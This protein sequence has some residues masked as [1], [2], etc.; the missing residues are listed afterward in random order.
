MGN[1]SEKSQG[2]DRAKRMES[3]NQTQGGSGVPFEKKP[4][5]AY[6]GSK[7]G[8]PTSGGKIKK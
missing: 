7:S 8:N 5:P 1:D 4:G 2:L 3:N 6:G